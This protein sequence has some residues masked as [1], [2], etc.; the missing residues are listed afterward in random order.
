MIRKILVKI[1]QLFCKHDTRYIGQIK[2][3]IDDRL[4]DVVYEFQ[5]KKC[6]KH[7]NIKSSKLI[8]EIEKCDNYRCAKKLV[9][10]SKIVKNKEEK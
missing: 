4:Y 5:C 10:M 1:E 9:K 3:W 8:P 6:R 2:T 7:M